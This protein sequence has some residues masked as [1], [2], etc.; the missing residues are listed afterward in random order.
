MKTTEELGETNQR[1]L[2]MP[3]DVVERSRGA[4]DGQRRVEEKRCPMCK[5]AREG[6]STMY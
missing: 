4:G 1:P 3:G 2:E 6:L 5:N